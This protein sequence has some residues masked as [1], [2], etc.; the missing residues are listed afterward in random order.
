ME[1]G[2]V[3]LNYAQ[4]KLTLELAL[5]LNNFESLKHVCIVDNNSPDNSKEILK[6]L[7]LIKGIKV[8]FNDENSGY[9]SGNNIGLN[10]L[11][12]ECNC[13]VVAIANPDIWIEESVLKKTF[14]LILSNEEFGLLAPMHTDSAGNF[15]EMQYRKIPNFYDMLSY[16]FFITR[17]LRSKQNYQ[18]YI[19]ETVRNIKQSESQIFECEV[20]WGCFLAFRSENIKKMGY[21]DDK[22][23]L[24]Y[25]EEILSENLRQE[26]LKTGIISDMTFEHRHDY[27]KAI[28]SVGK[29]VAMLDSEQ[30]FRKKYLHLSNVQNKILDIVNVYAIFE[31][32][33]ID[34]VI[35]LFFKK[36]IADW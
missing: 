30:Y 21:L 19:N 28:G 14:E 24:Y 16:S 22:L 5:H 29:F 26:Q 1:T 17:Y 13:S 18:K 32:K 11:I 25:E 20:I 8:I 34:K 35:K 12:E 15:N 9:S 23:F 3:I 6:T 10:Y 36:K 7:S 33:Q 2:V 4:P 31:K 27:S